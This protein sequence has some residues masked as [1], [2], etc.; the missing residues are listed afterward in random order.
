MNEQQLVAK[1]LD[2]LPSNQIF[3]IAQMCVEELIFTEELRFQ[4]INKED[5][6][7]EEYL[8]WTNSG[9]KLI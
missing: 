5:D 3:K 8:Y 1:Y 6:I 9:E 7:D 2:S 4:K